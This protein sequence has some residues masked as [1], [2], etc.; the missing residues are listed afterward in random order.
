MVQCQKARALI[1]GENRALSELTQISEPKLANSS[2]STD[3]SVSGQSVAVAMLG[4]PNQ[5]AEPEA[6]S[7]KA[8]RFTRASLVTRA[9]GNPYWSNTWF[10]PAACCSGLW[11]LQKGLGWSYSICFQ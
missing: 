7:L 11:T 10:N 9:I 4:N 8:G 2:T 5:T 1:S 3:S 6:P